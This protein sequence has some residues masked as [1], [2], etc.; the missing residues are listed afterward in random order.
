[1]ENEKRATR[2]YEQLA[3]GCIFPVPFERGEPSKVIKHVVYIMKENKTFDQILGDLE[4][5]VETDPD[6]VIFGEDI[7]PNAHALARQFTLCDNFYSKAEVSVQGHMWGTAANCND[8]VEKTFLHRKRPPAAGVEHAAKPEFGFIFHH[9]YRNNIPFR[10]YGQI[11]GIAGDLDIFAPFIDFKYGFWNLSVPDVVKAQEFIRELNAGIFPNFVYILLPNDHTEGSKPGAPTPRYMVADNDAA[12]GMIVEAISKSPY[13]KETAIF[14]TEDDPQSGA[15]HIDAH[16]TLM[17]VISPWAK[18]GYVSHVL[19]SMDSMWMTIEL[20]LGVGPMSKYD[21][22]TAP[23]YDC[24]TTKPDFSTYKAIPNPLPYEEN[25]GK[26]PFAEYCAG[27]DFDAPDQVP[28]MGEILWAIYRPGEPFPKEMSV[29]YEP[30]EDEVEETEE[31]ELYKRA[32]ER[33]IAL[34]KRLEAEGKLD[35][36]YIKSFYKQLNKRWKRK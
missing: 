23:M 12:L 3:S 20:I 33:H 34:G 22:Y 28:N 11:V 17:L 2:F 9:L 1:M 21:R 35:L 36:E 26:E 19:Y 30:D 7:T 14:V 8:Y 4:G 25:T 5:D 27:L 32:V 18:R 10:V 6:L 15:D 13:W 29:D 31:A 24:F 16:R